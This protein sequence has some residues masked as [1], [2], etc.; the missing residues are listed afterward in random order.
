MHHLKGIDVVLGMEWLDNNHNVIMCED[1]TVY[2]RLGKKKILII[3]GMQAKDSTCII[4]FT[5]VAVYLNKGCQG[6]LDS[7]LVSLQMR[8]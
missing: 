2:T 6:F 5:K 8:K 3:Q 1:R 4:S 7:V